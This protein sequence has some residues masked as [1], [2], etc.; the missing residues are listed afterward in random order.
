MCVHDKLGS[1]ISEPMVGPCVYVRFHGTSGRYHGSYSRRQLDRWAHVLAE[2][3]KA[4]TR[5]WAYNNNDPEAVATANALTL[6]EML[7]RLV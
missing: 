3:C 1:A 7:E 2:Q 5:L 6:R 4:P